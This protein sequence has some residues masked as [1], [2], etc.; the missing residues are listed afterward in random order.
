MVIRKA[1]GKSCDSSSAF[2]FTLLGTPVSSTAEQLC[3]DNFYLGFIYLSKHVII[4][5]IREIY[6]SSYG[7][8]LSYKYEVYNMKIEFDKKKSAE[9]LSEL[10]HET[11]DLG[12]KVANDAKAGVNAIVEKT[13]ADEHA[14]KLKKYNPLFPEQYQSENFNIPNIV[15]IV[16]DAVRRDI[17][18]CE[19]AIGWL[20]K[21]TGEEVLYL[22][23][24]AIE[25][26]KIEF[27]PAPV[28]NAVYYVDN[29][30]RGRFIQA[31][32][33]FSR[34]LKE[35][36]DELQHIAEFIGAKRC[37]IH[38]SE[39]SKNT[40]TK[41]KTADLSANTD[42]VRG[43]AK[44]DYEQSSKN[45]KKQYGHVEAEFGGLRF[46]KRPTLK[47]FAHDDSIN[48]LIDTCCSGKRRVKK[49]SLELSGS[50]CATMSQSIACAIDG[51]IHKTLN[52]K[53]HISLKSQ[54]KDEY[55]SKLFFHIEF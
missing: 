19:G 23:D 16:D 36:I 42:N 31:D 32:C 55:Q 17:D 20:G 8:Y 10:V 21:D 24:E 4:K 50:T 41:G 6:I 43:S 27:I 5:I 13:K 39:S 35:K 54:A 44:V 25:F 30:N 22:Y 2:I 52:A 48:N 51:V 45:T 18:V 9:T 40:K 7:K 29:F 15:V 12:K 37:L 3:G 33:I 46:P 38:I 34:T 49:L 28:C 53:G 14:R 47:W 1:D 26:S 11:V